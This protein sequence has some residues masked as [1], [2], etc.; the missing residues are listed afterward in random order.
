M[1]RHSTPVIHTLSRE[2]TKRQE[3]TGLFG[4]REDCRVRDW[5]DVGT[6]FSLHS[7]RGCSCTLTALP[8]YRDIWAGKVFSWFQTRMRSPP[9]VWNEFYFV[10]AHE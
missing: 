6:V 8:I 1:E 9:G 7:V 4:D 5:V 2:E 3:H 10:Y